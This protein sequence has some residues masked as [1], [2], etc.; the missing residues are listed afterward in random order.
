MEA[1][2]LNVAGIQQ[3]LSGMMLS[4]NDAPDTHAILRHYTALDPFVTTPE[5]E[6]AHQIAN[7][8]ASH[9]NGENKFL[10]FISVWMLV[11]APRYWWQEFDTY[12]VGVERLSQSTMHTITKRRLTQGDFESYIPEHYMQDLNHA[13]DQKDWL[14]VKSLLPESY[15]QT[16]VVCANVAALQ[17][18]YNQRH[19]HRLPEWDIFFTG[20]FKSLGMRNPCTDWITSGVATTTPEATTV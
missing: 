20:L 19:D 6:K 18:M 10:R 4:Y 13:I 3:A 16:R 17:N 11:R 15:L 12:K 2:V 1:R 7:R 8:L 5:G 14:K 9:N